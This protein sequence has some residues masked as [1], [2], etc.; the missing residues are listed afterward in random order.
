MGAD[1]VQ[2]SNL[3]ADSA[4]ESVHSKDKGEES[5][6][7]TTT[8]KSKGKGAIETS[9]SQKEEYIHVRARRG[10]ATNSHS[11]AERVW[12]CSL[13]DISVLCRLNM[14]C[15]NAECRVFCAVEKGEDQ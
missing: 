8:G 5:S 12:N 7:A 11:L 1:Q 13:S 15:R 4:N 3:H 10:Q 9:E 14:W 6:P 2:S